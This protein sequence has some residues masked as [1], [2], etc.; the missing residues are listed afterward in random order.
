MAENSLLLYLINLQQTTAC[1]GR[2]KKNKQPVKHAGELIFFTT[3]L[4]ATSASICH[5]GDIVW[6][7]SANVNKLR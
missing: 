6:R 7:L 4:T 2:E 3:C 1:W 5:G